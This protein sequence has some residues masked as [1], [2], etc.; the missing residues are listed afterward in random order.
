VP[1][2]PS[3]ALSNALAAPGDTVCAAPGT[4]TGS[5]T[6]TRRGTAAA[7][8]RYLCPQ[9]WQCRIV[10]SGGQWIWENTG[11]HVDIEGFD[12]TGP[13]TRIGIANEGSFVRILGNRV[14]QVSN[15]TCFRDGGAAILN[16]DYSS[17]DNDII[18]NVVLNI[19]PPGACN[20]TQGIY[21]SMLRGRIQNNLVFGGGSF[22]IHLWHAANAVTITNNLVVGSKRAGII[23]G[24]GDSPGGVTTANTL[25]AN[26][27]IVGNGE[28]CI[29]D[30]GTVDP[31]TNRYLN[32]G[33]F[34][35]GGGISV[36]GVVT[37]TV[38]ADPRFV[39]F[40][41]DGTGDYRLHPGSPA[42]D[43]GILDLA[44]PVA[45]GPPRPAVRVAPATDHDGVAR[46][47]GAGVDLGP[48]ER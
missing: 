3:A 13:S 7:R 45:D 30:L 5:V 12:V 9:K 43:A 44:P 34:R 24:A 46:P 17:T 28:Q 20:T 16:G 1:P 40:R 38:T 11:S 4:Y 36:R 39:D 18:G 42:I 35:N 10:A 37:G 6:T 48:Y 32:N 23:V 2:G 14:H 15:A 47:R 25:V 26:N 31:R 19:G 8:I 41:P 29:R 33:C 27:L 21:H 22:G